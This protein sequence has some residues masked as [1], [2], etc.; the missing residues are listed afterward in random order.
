MDA[1]ERRAQELLASCLDEWGHHQEAENVR[2]GEDLESY[3][4]E[5]R[6]IDQ[7]LRFGFETGSG[8]EAAAL[9]PPEGYV[10]VPA[11]LLRMVAG[12]AYPVSSEI[13]PRGYNW[14]E[15]YLDGV[16]PKIKAAFLPARPEV[17]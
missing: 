8:R 5:L 7:L 4:F 11:E 15:A 3:E 16:L 1:I 13:N 17:A 2:E 12:C 6:V 10:L 14:S 9:T